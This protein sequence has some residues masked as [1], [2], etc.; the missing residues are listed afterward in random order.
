MYMPWAGHYTGIARKVVE[1]AGY[2]P[3]EID[4]NGQILENV[5][6]QKS[7]ENYPD[8]HEKCTRSSAG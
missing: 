4:L 1:I 6:L 7:G 3:V 2:K 8:F 5:L